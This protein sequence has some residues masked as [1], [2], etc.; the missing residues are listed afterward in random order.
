M[1]QEQLAHSLPPHLRNQS[2]AHRLLGNEAHRPAGSALRRRRAHHGHHLA[3]LPLRQKSCRTGVRSLIECRIQSFISIASIASS[4]RTHRGLRDAHGLSRSHHRPTFGKKLKHSCA[5]QHLHGLAPT[6]CQRLQRSPVCLLQ[7]QSLTSCVR[8][9]T[10]ATRGGPRVN[11]LLVRGLG[12]ERTQSKLENSWHKYPISNIRTNNCLTRT[13][14]PDA[15]SN[16]CCSAASLGS[17]QRLLS[18]LTPVEPLGHVSPSAI[19]RHSRIRLILY[20]LS[21]LIPRTPT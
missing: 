15:M 10:W 11:L 21:R 5:L 19:F 9:H 12:I 18:S 16:P 14:N 17:P 3:G 13:D 2:P 4:Q 8:P 6:E 20:P 1:T 7:L